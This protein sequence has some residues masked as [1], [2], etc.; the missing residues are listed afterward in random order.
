MVKTIRTKIPFLASLEHFLQ[1]LFFLI[2]KIVQAILSWVFYW[3]NEQN[4]SHFVNH[5]KTEHH[6]K[7]KQTPT[8]QILNMFNIPALTAHT[9]KFPAGCTQMLLSWAN[10]FYHLLRIPYLVGGPGCSFAILQYSGDLNNKLSIVCY[11]DAL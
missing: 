8:I 5:W 9:K 7:T 6:W 10:T 11:S 3:K 4:G 2:Y 1:A